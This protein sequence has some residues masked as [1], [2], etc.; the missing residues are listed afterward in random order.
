MLRERASIHFGMFIGTSVCHFSSV[1]LEPN[2]EVEL[3]QDPGGVDY[4]EGRKELLV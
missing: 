1:S 3:S 2:S 4:K